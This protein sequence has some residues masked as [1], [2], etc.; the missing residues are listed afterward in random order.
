MV[1]FKLTR[2]LHLYTG[3]VPLPL[4]VN[5]GLAHLD[6]SGNDLD[7]TSLDESGEGFAKTKGLPPELGFPQR[8]PP[9]T[10]NGKEVPWYERKGRAKGE[11]EPA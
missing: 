9:D 4:L 6:I 1:S 5:P 2:N 10:E 11:L 7:W 3:A 8:A